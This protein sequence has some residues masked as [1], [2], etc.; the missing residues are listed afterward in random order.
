ML[1]SLAPSFRNDDQ[2]WVSHSTDVTNALLG[3]AG[4]TVTLRISNVVPESFTGPAG[5]GNDDISLDIAISAVPEPGS[6]ALVG[7]ALAGLAVS[8]RKLKLKI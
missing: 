8:R 3:N 4:Q 2:D 1:G 5:F 6:L 7:L